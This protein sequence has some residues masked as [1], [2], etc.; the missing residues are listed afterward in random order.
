MTSSSVT[1]LP[2]A[3]AGCHHGD[4][5]KH[6][7]TGHGFTLVQATVVVSDHRTL[8]PDRHWQGFVDHSRL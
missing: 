2:V 6:D 5:G 3:I 7:R 1:I 8:Q 4:E